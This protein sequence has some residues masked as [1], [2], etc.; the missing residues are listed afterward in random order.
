VK[1]VLQE[2]YPKTDISGDGQVV[3]INFDKYTIEL[4]PG[5]MQSDN[6]FKYPDTHDGGSWKYTDPLN[7][8]DECKK[9]DTKSNGNYYNFCR[10]SRKWKN[11]IGFEFGGLLI[12]TLVYN[13]FSDNQNYSTSSYNNYFD[14][15]VALMEYLKSQDP[16]QSYWLAVGSNQYVDNIGDGAFVTRATKAHKL[17]VESDDKNEEL[18][19]ILGN[20]FSSSHTTSMEN[21]NFSSTQSKNTE[22]FIERL[23]SVD[24]RYNLSIDCVVKQDGWRDFLLSHFLKGGGILKHHKKLNFFIEYT[25]APEPFFIYWKVRNVG[26]VAERRNCIRGQIVQTDFKKHNEHTDFYGPHFVECYI[27]KNGICVARDR[28][29][30]PIDDN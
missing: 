5:F 14:I 22:Q 15:L 13:L 3:V 27:V 30:V 21:D 9:C 4:V 2:R 1:D 28:I 19:S 7:E 25:N 29:D 26:A 12:D 20:D 23:F 10:L 17:L 16:E 11:N 8:R 6:K 24:I 18:Q